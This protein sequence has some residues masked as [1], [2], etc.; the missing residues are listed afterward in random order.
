MTLIVNQHVL[1]FVMGD[2]IRT[3]DTAIANLDTGGMTVQIHAQVTV[4][5]LNV[6]KQQDIA[7]LVSQNTTVTNV[8]GIAQ[9]TVQR[10]NVPRHLG[11]VLE[12]A[13]ITDMDQNVKTAAHVAT[14]VM[15]MEGVLMVLVKI[16][17]LQVGKEHT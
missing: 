14:S 2:A 9:L 4:Q 6:T 8:I 1:S 12:D 3:L 7:I 5:L 16:Q 11:I 17:L 13:R 15:K 10:M